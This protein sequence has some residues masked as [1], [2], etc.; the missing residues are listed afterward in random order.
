MGLYYLG[1]SVINVNIENRYGVLLAEQV[2]DFDVNIR[3]P[4]SFWP[5]RLQRSIDLP[6]PNRQSND[7]SN[8]GKIIMFNFF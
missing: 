7:R 1:K 5:N 2:G 4:V 8:Q 6:D 3:Y